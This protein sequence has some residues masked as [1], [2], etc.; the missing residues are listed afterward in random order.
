MRYPNTLRD[1]R[2]ALGLTQW[3]VA[4]HAGIHLNRYGRIEKGMT[5]PSYVEGVRLCECLSS[6]GEQLFLVAEDVGPEPA[7]AVRRTA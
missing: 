5:E 7:H 6:S 4:R 1:R 2:E 3:H